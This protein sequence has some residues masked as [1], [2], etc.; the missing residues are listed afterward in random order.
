MSKIED[1]VVDMI[2]NDR[3]FFASLLGQAKRIPDYT[4][5]TI[6]TGV[7]SGQFIMKFNPDFIEPKTLIETKALLE[8]ELMHIV[9]DHFTRV[10][11][12]DAMK[13]NVAG[14]LAINQLISGLPSDAL[15]IENVFK[16]D[17]QKL[18][19]KHRETADYYYDMLEK[20][21]EAQKMLGE[22]EQGCG[23]L[24]HGNGQQHDGSELSKEVMH[25]A[26]KEAVK[27]GKAKGNLPGELEKYIDEMFK[28]VVLSWRY[29]LR[30]FVSNSVKSGTKNSWKR[31]SRRY[32]TAQK[33]KIADRTIALTV[34]IDTSGSVDDGMLQQFMTEVSAIQQCYKSDIT[35]LECDAEVQREYKLKK[36]QKL[37]RDVHGR[38]GTSFKPPFVYVKKHNIRTDAMIY[39][40]DLCGDFPDKKPTTPVM[41][42]Y[43]NCGWGG[44]TEV[45]FGIVVNLVNDNAEDR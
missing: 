31:P 41:W 11:G 37:K 42:A 45:P 8:H 17:V 12:H 24:Q 44:R 9:M 1:A 35:V 14:D 16:G 20:S 13:W 10:T 7:Q 2:V 29:L 6:A 5:P 25:Q 34:V 40:T 21:K 3:V 30:R 33:G 18:N 32:G 39:F 22:G 23:S 38:G 36:F 4:I 26:V 19:I 27:A 28:P 43:Y 15:T